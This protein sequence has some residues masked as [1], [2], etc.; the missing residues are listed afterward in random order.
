M[1]G[2][3]HSVLTETG[4]IPAETG[5][6]WPETATRV[7]SLDERLPRL[8]DQTT[9]PPLWEAV[10]KARLKASDFLIISFI[11]YSTA[12]E[13]GGLALKGFSA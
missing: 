2:I 7:G 12:S 4:S 13:F 8:K 9:D 1:S 6:F 11:R 5:S 10:E 3:F